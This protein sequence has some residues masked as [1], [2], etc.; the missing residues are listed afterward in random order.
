MQLLSCSHTQACTQQP[1]LPT[2]GPPLQAQQASP[3]GREVRV[4]F[5]L[6]YTVK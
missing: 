5:S 3:L 6:P 4:V 2:R 1:P